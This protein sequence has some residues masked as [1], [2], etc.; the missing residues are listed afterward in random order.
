[1]VKFL[2]K[3]ACIVALSACS[4]AQ[5]VSDAER[6]LSFSADTDLEHSIARADFD[7]AARDCLADAIYHEAKNTGPIGLQAV[8]HVVMN[9][10]AST[11]FPNTVC[12]V[13]SHGEARGRCQFAYR[14]DGLAETYDDRPAHR[15]ALALAESFLTNPPADITKGARFFH[16]SWAR[17]NAFFKSRPRVG[18]YGG[19]TFYL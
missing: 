17:P 6:S 1:M 4:G 16:A 9:R 11:E 13:V 3:L 12:G 15:R 10:V 19:N 2:P 5:T 8:A 7:P 14:C 18:K